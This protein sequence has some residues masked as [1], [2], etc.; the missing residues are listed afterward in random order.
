M[1][2]A[3]LAMPQSFVKPGREGNQYRSGQDESN[4]KPAALLGQDESQPHRSAID[5]KSQKLLQANHPRSGLW[6]E[7]AQTW[8]EGDSQIRKRHAKSYCLEY[9]ERLVPG[10]CDCIAERRLLMPANEEAE[11]RS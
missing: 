10:L 9:G 1:P 3:G 2:P 11:S 4:C 8:A 6:K 7:T 5:W